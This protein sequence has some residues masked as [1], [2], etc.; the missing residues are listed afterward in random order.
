MKKLL[1]L[2]SLLLAS[3][4]LA[5]DGTNHAMPIFGGPGFIGFR[6]VG[7]CTASQVI[8]WPSG[9]TGDPACSSSSPGFINIVCT[10]PAPLTTTNPTSY[11]ST[12]DQKGC[13]RIYFTNAE[14]VSAFASG[15]FRDGF[16]V[17]QFV[18]DATNYGAVQ[19]VNYG[20]RAFTNG[21]FSAG[22]YTSVFMD[23][24]GLD[25]TAIGKIDDAS[26]GVSGITASAIQFGQGIASNEF[27]CQNPAGAVQS[28][29]MSCVQAII[30]GK[31]AANDLT[32][33]SYG[34]L[35]TNLGK[36]ATAAFAATTAGTGGD[37][38]NYEY[39]LRGDLA[40]VETAAISMPQSSSGNLGTRIL[41][42]L[43]GGASYTEYDRAGDTYNWAI[44]GS[45]VVSLNSTAWFSSTLVNQY[46]NGSATA[47]TYSFING[48]N[49]GMYRVGADMLGFA[50]AGALRCTIDATASF[51]CSSA[52]S[53]SPQFNQ[54][55]STA[56]ANGSFQIF[57]KNRSGGN[58]NNG[59]ILGTALFQGFANSAQRAASMV[60]ANQTGAVSG[61]N[62]PSN[63]VLA[64][65]NA[66][67]SLNQSMTIDQ[68]GH[69]GFT[70][71]APPTASA[72]AGFAVTGSDTA[73]RIT[74]TSATTCTINFGTAYAAAPFCQVTPGSAASTSFITTST[75][76]L[77]VT[78]GTA[79]TAF[80][81]QCFGA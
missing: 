37:S 51:A 62:V 32:H 39:I 42:D 17:N 50:T 73:G 30:S 20:L 15:S 7:P 25:G 64:T 54:S 33:F 44:N 21:P 45:G 8:G 4:A 24:V 56:D 38:G 46:A 79:Q 29:S 34:I 6:E 59:D 66:A 5:Q 61:N 41:Y 80:F 13:S 49:L 10:S 9:V 52:T 19:H 70:A 75:T 40:T 36:R 18:T 22:N 23:L 35:S 48:T 14:N 1:L 16:Y 28:L 78:F 12:Y 3:P 72:C 65:S 60:R 26:R 71:S 53:N 55:N 47:P 69:V 58:S 68:S 77:A 76:Q 74:Y 63:I 81:Y 2:L 43:T 11:F 27:A 57:N 31:V 67:G